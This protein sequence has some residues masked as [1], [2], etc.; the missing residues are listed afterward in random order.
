M[1]DTK[2]AQYSVMSISRSGSKGATDLATAISLFQN[3]RDVVFRLIAALAVV[4]NNFH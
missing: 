4:E 3:Q 2:V 1:M